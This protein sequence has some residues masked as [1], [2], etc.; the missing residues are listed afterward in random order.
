MVLNQIGQSNLYVN[1]IVF[2]D[3]NLRKINMKKI[4]SLVA[5]VI[6]STTL[7]AQTKW[8]ADKAHSKIGF[9]VRHMMLSGVDGNFGKF[10]AHLFSSKEDFTDAVFDITIDVASINTDN[11]S[12]DKDLRSDHFFDV[13]KYP[14]IKF[15]STSISKVDNKNYKLIGNLAMHG[16]TKTVTFNLI[17]NE[18]GPNVANHKPAAGFKVTGI[19]SR[20]DF[21]MGSV[22][23]AIVGDEITI[24][25]N[26]E[27]TQE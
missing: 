20:S 10:E 4:A 25:A 23:K 7:F 15:K 14:E 13:A 3:I 18:A 8:I 26:G 6:V 21:G 1:Y 11:E 2:L 12:R 27:F 19:I 9:S 16:V 5:V 17:L 24:R 22:P